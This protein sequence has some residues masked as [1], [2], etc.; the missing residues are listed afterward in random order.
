[1]KKCKETL[2]RGK[3]KMHM[4]RSWIGYILL[5]TATQQAIAEEDLFALPLEE[6]SRLEVSI[7]TGT[8]KPI[9]SAPAIAS[10]ITAHDIEAMGA[11][12]L[13]T[14]LEMVPGLH[15]SHGGFI[16]ASRY[17]M[18]GIVSTYNPHTLVLI[19]GIPQTSLF[20]GDRG[21]RLVA[22][23]GLPVQMIERVEIIRGPGSAVYGACILYAS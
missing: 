3:G 18:R 19:N 22:M 13:D 10:V 21:E 7:A 17:F 14:V 15:V 12:D 20:T 5:C 8:P 6:L 11:Q 23:T 4:N 1:M 16:Y 2:L 9:T